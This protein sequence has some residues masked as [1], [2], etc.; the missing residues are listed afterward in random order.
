MLDDVKALGFKIPG[1]LPSKFGFYFGKNDT[2]YGNGIGKCHFLAIFQ[3]ISTVLTFDSL[4]VNI[5]TGAFGLGQLGRVRF[6][7]S[8]HFLFA[9]IHQLFVYN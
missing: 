2:W 4:T 7:I 8:H 6:E 1:E 5:H 3:S 9:R